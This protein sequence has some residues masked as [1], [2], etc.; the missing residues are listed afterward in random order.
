MK[1]RF[2]LLCFPFSASSFSTGLLGKW[3]PNNIPNIM[4][5]VMEDKVIGTMDDKHSVEMEIMKKDE[6]E[7]FLDKIQLKRKPA[8]WFNVIKYKKYI[9]IFQ[10][11]RRYGIVCQLSFM[12][13]K[14]LKILS[15][16]GDESHHFLLEKML[17]D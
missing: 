4:I 9:T 6:D 7:I 13:E 8:D 3:K 10:K 1:W 15:K 11:I 12:D 2:L 16:I 14:N 17:E 5:N